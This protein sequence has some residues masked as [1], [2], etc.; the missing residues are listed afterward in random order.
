M[1]TLHIE[2]LGCRKAMQMVRRG[3]HTSV[4]PVRSVWGVHQLLM[5]LVAVMVG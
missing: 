1:W 3:A 2:G 5:L 4:T